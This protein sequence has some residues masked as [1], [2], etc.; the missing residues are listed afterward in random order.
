MKLNS[1]IEEL[2][3]ERLCSAEA[4]RRKMNSLMEELDQ[5]RLRSP[6]PDN[7]KKNLMMETL[8]KYSFCWSWQQ[9]DE[10]SD[11]GIFA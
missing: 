2:D 3:Q 10:F 1:V 4:D 11:G 9:E 5:E 7:R 8:G 6:Q